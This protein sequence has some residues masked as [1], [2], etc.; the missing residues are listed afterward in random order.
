MKCIFDEQNDKYLVSD[1][2]NV[3]N[4]HPLEVVDR[5]S[6][7]QLHL[8]ENLKKNVSGNCELITYDLVKPYHLI[9]IPVSRVIVMNILIHILTK[10]ICEP[11]AQMR[12]F[13]TEKKT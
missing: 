10:M 12:T 5:V 7:I 9:I 13:Q 6:E 3:Y 11:S 4:F 1:L 2:T 8:G